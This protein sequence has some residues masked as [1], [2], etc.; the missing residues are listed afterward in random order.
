MIAD[1]E[2]SRKFVQELFKTHP[3]IDFVCINAGIQRGMDFTQPEHLDMANMELELKTNYT[4]PVYLTKALLPY[5]TDRKQPVALAYTTSQLGL[6][7]LTSRPNYSA[8][9]AAMHSFILALRSQLAKSD[10]NL[11]VI[12][13]YPPAVQTEMHNSDKQPDLKNGDQIGMPLADFTE[14]LWQ[15]LREGRQD[16]PVGTAKPIW[17]AIEPERVRQNKEFNDT[18]DEALK[19][20]LA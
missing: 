9:K 16:I 10:P 5:L 1:Y 20:F 17:E 18:M 15:G 3:D 2:Q 6:I 11:K 8:S 12:E 7:T 19:E 14:E 4:A 13:I